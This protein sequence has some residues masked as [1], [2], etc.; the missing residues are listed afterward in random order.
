[1]Q[2]VV[3]LSRLR[4]NIRIIR[5]RLSG[6]FCAVIKANAY[7]HGTAVAPYVEPVVDCFMV[8]TYHE[9][10]E[11]LLSGVNKPILVMGGEL[12]TVKPDS[13]IIPAVST[14][15]DAEAMI[16]AGINFSVAVDTGMNRLGATAAEL[17]EIAAVCDS[18]GA[19]PWSVYSHVYNG[20]SSAGEQAQ[21]LS[22]LTYD[23]PIF[24]ARRHIYCSCALD[25][26]QNERFDMTRC[27]IAMYGFAQGL[28]TALKAR[29]KIVRIARV[30]HGSHVG[31]G[32]FILERDATVATVRMGYADGLRRT[33]MP[34]YLKVRGV[35][36]PVLGM[37]C[38]DLTMI[39]ISGVPA[40]VGEFAY[41]IADKA[42]VEYLAKAYNTIVYE[43]LTGLNGRAERIYM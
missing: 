41:M 31:Y 4:H 26:P 18:Y 17:K 34:L 2:I 23:I 6:G 35:K 1:M 10:E 40:R 8:A 5:S 32:D 33:E 13:R 28:E 9:A 39:D 16:R 15:R 25:L 24:K 27:G 3:D 42:D 7:G 43:V 22:D 36:C 37:P 11:A 38:M 14:A 29:A 19:V 21:K 12:P 30:S 20:M